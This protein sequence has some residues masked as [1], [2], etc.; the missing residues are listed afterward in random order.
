MS[1]DRDR[2]PSFER[3]LGIRFFVGSAEQAVQIGLQGGLVVVPAAPALVELQTDSH[4]REALFHSDLAITDSGLMVLVWRLMSRKRIARVSGLKYLKLLLERKALEP[5]A[6]VL[7]IMPNAGAQ[8]ENLAWLNA[9][10]YDFT[11]AN[12]YVAPSY[13]AGSIGDETLLNLVRARRP[14]HIVICLGGGTQERLGLMLKRQSGFRPSIHC[15]GAAIGFLTGNQARI[16]SW[17]DKFFLGWLFR[18][19]SEPRKFVPRYLKGCRLV[20]MMIRYRQHPP[21]LDPGTVPLTT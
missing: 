16:P 10:G 8:D 4:Y 12:C 21:K 5:S 14:R 9:Q 3:I 6:S 13:P 2:D 17:A 20:P 18:C 7:W 11:E 1:E 19:L 15:L